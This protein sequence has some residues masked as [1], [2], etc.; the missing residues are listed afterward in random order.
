MEPTLFSYSGSLSIIPVNLRFLRRKLN[1]F[2]QL[3]VSDSPAKIFIYS[4]RLTSTAADVAET[5]SIL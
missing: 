3:N 1:L 4:F 5:K 2:F